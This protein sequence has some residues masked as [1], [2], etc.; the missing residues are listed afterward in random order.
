MPK[1]RQVLYIHPAKQ[2]V[3]F[4]PF[5]S[6]TV[7][8]PYGLIPVGLPALIN[9]LR[10]S[11]VRV[12]GVNLPMEQK[13]NPRFSL[14]RWLTQ[15]QA[16]RV[17]LIDLHWYEHCYGAISVANVC[18]EVLPNAR[19]V[20]GGLTASAFSD[21][22]LRHFPAVDFII[23]GDAE[24]PL[25]MLVQHLLASDGD[26]ETA[27]VPDLNAIPN[28]SY[29][30]GGRVV[31]NAR[32]YCAASSDLDTLNFVD[33]DFLAHHDAY[34]GHEYIVTDLE[35]VRAATDKS[36]YRGRWLCTARGCRY[37]CSY[38]GG[39]RSAHKA[40]AGRD[41]I[42]PRSPARMVDD[43]ERL[44]AAG[45]TQAS[46][47]Y[48]ISELGEAYWRDLFAGMRDRG[49]KIGLY[50]ECFQDPSPQFVEDFVRSVDMAHACLA[51]SP[52]S[53]SEEVRRLNGKHYSN[54]QLFNTLD[55]LN[56]YNMPIFVYFSLNLPGETDETFKETLALAERIYTYY[57]PSLLKILTSCHT[58]DPQ[59]PMSDH[60]EAYGI[61]VDMT[62]FMD[63]YAY[64]RD[65]QVA[66][67]EA[68]TGMHRGFAIRD[69]EARD[70]AAMAQAWDA[71]RE[72]RESSW[73][74]VP[75]SW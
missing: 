34:Y 52:L 37:E 20:L 49:V 58:I 60:A 6:Q 2:A 57:P 1:V 10:E 27:P 16:A 51:L 35:A 39:C 32:T 61:T 3:G 29:R 55:L 28:L 70:L 13:L 15:R 7:G 14:Q 23:R 19:T 30:E 5:A 26:R 59:S 66:G 42:V 44:E 73:W 54:A 68:L 75:P 36:A 46:L 40:L 53:G 62:T 71:A 50:N 43:L 56:L 74:P 11:G 22:I 47:S 38:C 65:T 9:R 72:G 45:V 8:R 31:E 24:M 64:C 25:A 21:E 33:I 63:Y 69:P 18:R 67:P 4:R 17:V 12:E 48:D 41:G